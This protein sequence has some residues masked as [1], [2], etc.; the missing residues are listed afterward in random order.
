MV[1]FFIELLFMIFIFIIGRYILPAAE[2]GG[3]E[4]ILGSICSTN[5]YYA[6]GIRFQGLFGLEYISFAWPAIT[7]K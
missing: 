3:Q 5:A 6:K 7:S 4:V 2:Y 1:F